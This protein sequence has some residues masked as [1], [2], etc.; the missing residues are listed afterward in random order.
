MSRRAHLWFVVA[1]GA[2]L[3]IGLSRFL[4]PRFVFVVLGAG[5]WAWRTAPLAAVPV[6][7]LAGLLLAL[8]ARAHDA[9]SCGTLLPEG[10]VALTVRLSDP[11]GAGMARARPIGAACHGT[12]ALRFTQQ[13][14]HPA[15]AVLEVSGRW[16]PQLSALRPAAGTLVVRTHRLL[17]TEPTPAERLRTAIT[18]TSERLYG[19]RAP[20]VDA[21]ILGRRG[22]M[23][24][25]LREDFARSGLVHLL[26]ISGFHVGLLTSWT[27]LVG[28]ALGVRRPRAF[29]L[30]A[31]VA[32]GYVA[33]LGWQAPATRAAVLGSLVAWGVVRQRSVTAPA[34][35]A[36]AALG[37]MLVD[38]WAVFDLGAWLSVGSIAGLMIATRWSDRALGSG[39][40]WRM[41][42]ASI[43][44]TLATAPL[45]A[46]VLG[47]VAPIG[48]VLNFAAIPLAAVAVP[49]VLATLLV[50]PVVPAL[51]AALASGSG[52]ALALLEELARL[53]ARVPGGHLIVEPGMPAAAPWLLL[54]GLGLWGMWGG[55]TSLTALR[56]WGWAAAVAVWA[57]AVAD[58]VRG[59]P[60][61]HDGLALHFLDVGQGDATAVRTPGGR[62]ILV[63][64]GPADHRHDAGRRVVA[65]FLARQ[66]AR[67]LEAAL[68]SH[69][70]AD[71][72]GGLP[73][74]LGRVP[75]GLV[76]E[77]GM[78]AAD[79]G[80]AAFLDRVAANGWRWRPARRGE[81]FTVDGVTFSV[82]HPDT[83]WSW[84]GLDLNENSLVV[85][86]EWGRFAALLTG[87]AGF[88]AESLLAGRIGPVD[89]LK[90][91]HHGSRGST[92]AALLAETRPAAAVIS[93]GRRNRH[94]HPAPEALRRLEAAGVRVFRT[95][96]DGT[97]RVTVGPGAMTVHGAAGAITYLLRR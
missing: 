79:A 2:G 18:T 56:R 77:P 33:F 69:A 30:G 64:A 10:R 25:E 17:A 46:A 38:P 42:S 67:R 60:D 11:S 95:D 85:R 97:I 62:W 93:A 36:A 94:G 76:L 84:W 74:V 15:G 78:P 58:A 61:G 1:V 70:H 54:L 49:G 52:L 90:V 50:A 26:S 23:D 57:L 66:G 68:V 45:T 47:A 71:H 5:A 80:Y 96:L 40:G 3:M 72:L 34:L 91:G 6:G 88:P 24:P 13:A 20:V 83:T 63:D 39:W 59:A 37:V 51:A 82:L 16:L 22:A 29:L 8:V 81:Q 19:S 28:L 12:V 31:V 32:V 21:L 86:V 55:A 14:S 75:A 92:G 35:L 41:L 4:D 43:G 27:V 7:A 48:I 9:G 65:P 53:G 44:S 89:L 87:D 73:S